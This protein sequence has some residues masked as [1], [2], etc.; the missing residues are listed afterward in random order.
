MADIRTFETGATRDTDQGKLDYEGFLHPL[1]IQAY[2]E[3]MHR[4]R[5]QP[6]GQLR[7]SDNWQKGIP[8]DSYIKSGWRHF[9]DWW[10]LHRGFT[11]KQTLVESLCAIIFNA[12]GYL[13]TILLDEATEPRP[14]VQDLGGGLATVKDP[15]KNDLVTIEVPSAFAELSKKLLKRG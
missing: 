12:S 6:D 7:T 4:H 11:A 5:L 9:M 10:L 14:M 2:G 13:S 3:Y 15:V 1:V 8:Q